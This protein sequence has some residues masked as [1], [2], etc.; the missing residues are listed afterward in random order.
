MSSGSNM[1]RWVAQTFAASCVHPECSLSTR[2][3]DIELGK[4]DISRPLV[5]CNMQAS[6][7]QDWS[8]EGM[9]IVNFTGTELV[10]ATTHLTLFAAIVR[11][12]VDT[13]ECSQ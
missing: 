1:K 3:A 13:V 12:F 7:C 10:C 8:D 2:H 5:P 4:C 9:T 11:G 6:A